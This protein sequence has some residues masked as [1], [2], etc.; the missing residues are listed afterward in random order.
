M[1]ESKNVNVINMTI[2]IAGGMKNM[3]NLYDR[4]K[5]EFKAKL[6]EQSDYYPNAIKSIYQELKITS[7]F[8]DLKY[9]TVF[10]LSNFLNIGKYDVTTI[11]N[12]FEQT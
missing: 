9:G 5:P 2:M 11:Y 12:L 10:E 3:N 7:S 8:I 6:E 1:P 4:L